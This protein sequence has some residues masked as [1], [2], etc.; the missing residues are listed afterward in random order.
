MFQLRKKVLGSIIY[1][2]IGYSFVKH[3]LFKVRINLCINSIMNLTPLTFITKSR[4]IED[5]LYINVYLSI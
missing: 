3:I 1:G 4:Y 5:F 2:L